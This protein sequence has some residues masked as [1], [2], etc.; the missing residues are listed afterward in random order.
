MFRGEISTR[1][2][3][4]LGQ[5]W[6]HQQ[7]NVRFALP[8]YLLLVFLE[9]EKQNKGVKKERKPSL[10]VTWVREVQEQVYQVGS[11]QSPIQLQNSIPAR[12]SQTSLLSSLLF[13][14][15][16]YQNHSESCECPYKV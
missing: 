6:V 9:P 5:T 8:S 3:F 16:K 15:F 7:A 4:I 2:S 11:A 13:V 10:Y 1:P 14:K 12:V